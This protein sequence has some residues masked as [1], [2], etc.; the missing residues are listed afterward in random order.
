[1][2]QLDPELTIYARE[3]WSPASDAAVALEPE[4][5]LVPSELLSDGLTYFLEID[6][7]RDIVPDL[8]G[9]SSV[10]TLEKWCGRLIYYAQ[11]DA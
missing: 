9:P 4:E 7:A 5:G 3:P 1:V 11:Y 2:H 6:G 8:S 10:S